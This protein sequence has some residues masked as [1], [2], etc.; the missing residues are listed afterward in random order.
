[1]NEGV[2]QRKIHNVRSPLAAIILVTEGIRLVGWDKASGEVE[3]QGGSEEVR[4]LET[5]CFICLLAAASVARI[6]CPV[7]DLRY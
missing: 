5:H 7:A 4:E 1:M 2:V 6:P 3:R